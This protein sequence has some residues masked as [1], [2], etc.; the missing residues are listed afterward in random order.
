MSRAIGD[1]SYK[2]QLERGVDEQ[3]VIAKPDVVSKDRTAEDRFVV[4][5]C[6]GIFDVLSNQELVD[7]INDE[8]KKDATQSL[9]KICEAVCNRCLAPVS[10]TGGPTTAAG[11]DNMTVVII[12]LL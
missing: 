12:K 9:T 5:A 3:L 1:Y 11:T 7:F 2:Q 4:V 10:A 6:D 8:I